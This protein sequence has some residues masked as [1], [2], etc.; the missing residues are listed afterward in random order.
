MAMPPGYN[1]FG[2]TGPAPGVAPGSFA[3]QPPGSAPMQPPPTNS[4]RG[5]AGAMGTGGITSPI[6]QASPY[7]PQN[8][9]RPYGEVSNITNAPPPPQAPP[10]QAPPGEGYGPG[11]GETY[12]Q[13]H[14]GQ[15]DQPTALETFA[16]QQLN[17]NN[18]YYD[19][20]RQQQSDAIN[21]QMAARG[22]YNSGGALSALG[23]ADAALYAQQ[24]QDMGNLLGQASN[25]G[26]NRLNAGMGQAGNIQG[27]TQQRL[28]QQF[29]EASD[30]AHLGAG[31]YGQFYGQG[32][33]QSGDAAMAGINAGANAAGLAAQGQ[34]GRGNTLTDLFKSLAMG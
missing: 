33:Q 17:G 18:P 23:N 1:Q 6:P 25:L 30:L 14:I 12:G 22:H 11:F 15:Y 31:L 26:L 34:A 9:V 4:N 29:G 20:L 3:G 13:Q 7:N 10:P 19:R 28:G 24:F 8:F 5:F 21:Q 27:L 32:G 2:K 16:N